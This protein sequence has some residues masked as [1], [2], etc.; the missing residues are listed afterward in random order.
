MCYSVAYLEK[1][2]SK[3]VERY[4]NLLPP[5]WKDTS[6]FK[7]TND[8]FP[9]SYFINAFIHPELPVITEEGIRIME[10]G[11]IPF[12]VNDEEKAAKLRKG[13]LNAVG[14][15]VFVKPSFKRVI[16]SK[17][18]ILPISGFFEWRDHQ[19]KK[20]PYFIRLKDQALFSLACIFDSWTNKQSG[21]IIESFSVITCPANPLM[22][23][24]HNR[25]KRM[26]LI[27]EPAAEKEWTNPSLNEK[28][29]HDLI[30]P[31]DH[32]HMEAYTVSRFLNN[33]RSRRN[34]PQALEQV[35]YP[36]LPELAV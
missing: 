32:Q 15:T 4:K 27:L 22:E 36:E 34:V 24:V 26:P 7:K 20:Y 10:W 11:L 25:K 13:T 23:V 30:R 29:I 9:H 31:F 6:S 1:K 5:G 19:G 35:N 17:R 14:E 21:E 3:L 12:W 8:I 2:Q 33:V 28:S 18:G 16:R